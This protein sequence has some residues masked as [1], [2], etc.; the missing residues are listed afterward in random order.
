MARTDATRGV[1]KAPAGLDAGVGGVEALRPQLTDLEIG[2]LN[3]LGVN[4]LRSI[5]R[6]RVT[7]LGRAHA[8]GHRPARVG[9][10]VPAGPAHGALPRGVALP[11]HAVGRVRAE[12]RAALGADP[13]QRRRVH[14]HASSAR[15]RSP[16]TTPR[17]AFFVKCDAETT[18]QD[19]V[20]LGIVNI[21]VGFAPLKPAEF[22][23]IKLQQMAGQTG[24]A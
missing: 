23:V 17:E 22:V 9:V 4:C 6:R 8:R 3:P 16:G 1:W 12:R 7:R 18:T 2:R 21:V 20:N 5:A 11:R 19:D 24:G 15:A 13:A 10:E 14:E